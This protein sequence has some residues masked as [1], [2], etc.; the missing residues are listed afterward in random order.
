MNVRIAIECVGVTEE[1]RGKGGRVML[2]GDDRQ[3]CRGIS[4]E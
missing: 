2:K 4:E 1:G 3:E